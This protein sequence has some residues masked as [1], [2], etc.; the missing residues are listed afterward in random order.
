LR[1]PRRALQ[2]AGAQE[3]ASKAAAG[4]LTAMQARQDVL[5]AE[6]RD[7]RAECAQRW[8]AERAALAQLEALERR[9][10]AAEAAAAALRQQ[11]QQAQEAVAAQQRINRQVMQRKEEVEWQ[12]MA[13]LAQVRGRAAVRLPPPLVPALLAR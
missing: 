2:L 4:A 7:M 8:A 13:A 3:E 11:L 10:E 6:Q 12:L 1:R 9:A 5:V